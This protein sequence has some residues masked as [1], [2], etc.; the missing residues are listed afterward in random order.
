MKPVVNKETCIACG[1]CESVCSATPNV[2]E[3]GDYS[4]VINPDACTE[5]GECVDSCPT[6]SIEL[7]D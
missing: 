2:F 1:T 5:C 3:V 4:K 6:D 7:V